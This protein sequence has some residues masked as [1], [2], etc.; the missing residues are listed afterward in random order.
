VDRYSFIVVDLH[1]RLLAGL[2]AHF[3]SHMP[4]HAVGL[5]ASLLVSAGGVRPDLAKGRS[6][7]EILELRRDAKIAREITARFTERNAELLSKRGLPVT[8]GTLYLAHFAGGAEQWR[9]CRQRRMPTPPLLWRARTQRV[10]RSETVVGQRPIGRVLVFSP[11]QRPNHITI[12]PTKPTITD[13]TA[14]HKVHQT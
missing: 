11:N 2:P 13:R 6:Q 9:S 4:S 1:H 3:E 14:A 10:D 5:S 7:A 8:P 12:S